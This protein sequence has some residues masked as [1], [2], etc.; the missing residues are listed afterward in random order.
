MRVKKPSK[1]QIALGLLVLAAVAILLPPRWT[2]HLSALTQVL[3]PAQHAANGLVDFSRDQIGK[4]S[5][6]NVPYE[7]HQETVA[8]VEALERQLASASE[9]LRRLQQEKDELTRLR[10]QGLPNEVTLVPARV[11]AVDP[12]AWRDLRMLNRGA[13]RAIRQQDWVTSRRSVIANAGPELASGMPVLSGETLVGS[14]ELA[15]PFNS[16]IVLLSDMSNDRMPVRVVPVDGGKR[17]PADAQFLLRGKG[18]ST[19]ELYDVH[20]QYVEKKQIQVDD[21]VVTSEGVSNLPIP[22]TIGRISKIEK[23]P[24]RP[25]LY[26]CEV[27]PLVDYAS[28]RDVYVVQV[29]VGPGQPKG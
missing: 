14:I 27:T 16:R 3:A 25:L 1:K 8:R 18:D 23:T 10:N 13:T 19:M 9:A 11:I 20:F 17:K 29:R 4:V 12:A 24:N 7:Q 5:H 6:W 15:N 28:I 2:G 21:Y 26:C 22:M